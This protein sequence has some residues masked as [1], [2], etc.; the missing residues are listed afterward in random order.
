M[1]YRHKQTG[2]VMIVLFVIAFFVFVDLLVL[3]IIFF[4]AAL[5]AYGIALLILFMILMVISGVLFSSMT[6]RVNSEYLS[7][8]FAFGF[9]KKSKKLAD[10]TSYRIVKNPWLYGWGIR[11]LPKGWLY[12]V[13]GL[14]AVEVQLQSGTLFRLGTDEPEKL[15][16]AL[17]GARAVPG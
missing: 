5:N 15:I 11:R 8:N 13:S 14:D 6:I 12:N 10:I 7:W 9:W 4:F 17:E 3:G 16:A 2:F 1:N